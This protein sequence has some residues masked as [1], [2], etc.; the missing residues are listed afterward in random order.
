MVAGVVEWLKSSP[1]SVGGQDCH[2]EKSGAFT[3]NVSA[4]M[5][6][7]QGCTHVIVGHSERR[8]LHGETSEM[9]AAKARAVHAE[10]MTAIICVGETDAER[11]AGKAESVVTDQLKKSIP[12]EATPGNTVV[13]YEPVW[14]IGTGKTAS[15]DDIR[16]MHALIRGQVG[17]ISILYG[18]SV[19]GTNAKEIMSTPNVDGVLVGGASLKAG[20]FID[21]AKAC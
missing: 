18:G 6:K 1:L 20:E 2:A 14:A 21:I 3:G 13:A 10:G 5:L 17:E 12:G 7:D 4:A 8:A 19:K 11:T 15:P 9:V 16:Q